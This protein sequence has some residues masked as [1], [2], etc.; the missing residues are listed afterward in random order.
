[1]IRTMA[2]SGSAREWSSRSPRSSCA[3]RPAAGQAV[4]TPTGRTP[5]SR[6]ASTSPPPRPSPSTTATVW[7]SGSG[8]RCA[9]WP[10]TSAPSCAT[11]S[12]R[13]TGC[14]AGWPPRCTVRPLDGRPGR[15]E[16]RRSDGCRRSDSGPSGSRNAGRRRETPT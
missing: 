8:R 11:G 13:S 16:D 14:E 9:W 12:W 7:S 3:S 4:S 5:G 6:C 2:S 10:T 1:W 15:R